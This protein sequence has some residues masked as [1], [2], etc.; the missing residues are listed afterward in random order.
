MRRSPR[1]SA[2]LVLAALAVP[3]A[4]G[5]V[6]TPA[7]A[8]TSDDACAEALNPDRRSVYRF[9]RDGGTLWY[10]RVVVTATRAD[11]DRY[12]IQVDFGNRTVFH[13]FGMS[14]YERRDGRWVNDGGLGDEGSRGG[15]Y[16]QSMQV[17]ERYR[18]DRSY[19]IR[20]DG[21]WYRT[22]SISRSNL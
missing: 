11:R 16:T 10:G 6:A 15:S 20:H 21:R 4:A 5:A 3:A 7:T 13:G 8:A 22:T 2:L 12:C 19:S 17:P 18:I 14:G 1:S 9:K